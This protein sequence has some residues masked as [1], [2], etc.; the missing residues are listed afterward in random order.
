MPPSVNRAYRVE[1]MMNHVCR[2]VVATWILVFAPAVQAQQLLTVAERSDYKATAKHAE[3]VEYCQQLAKMS[4]LVR[5]AEFGTTHEGRKL[6]LVILAD[7]PVA[8]PEEAAR[9]GKLVIF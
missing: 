4:P 5:V 1:T 9:S 3:V 6:P 7:P 8:T 2:A